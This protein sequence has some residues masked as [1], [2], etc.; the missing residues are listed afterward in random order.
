[1]SIPQRFQELAAAYGAD[2]RRWPADEQH[3]F[4]TWAEHPDAQALLAQEE[5]LDDFLGQLDDGAGDSDRVAAAVLA[6]I[7]TPSRV[8]STMA[9]KHMPRWFGAGLFASA[10]LGLLIGFNADTQTAVTTVA[11]SDLDLAALAMG[12]YTLQEFQQP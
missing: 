11:D 10:L 9:N 5:R 7:A 6:R 4:D 2:R 8:A 1:M 3:L 12:D